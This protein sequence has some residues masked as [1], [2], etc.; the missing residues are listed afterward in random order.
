[1]CIDDNKQ[2][3]D[4]RSLLDGAVERQQRTTMT[5]VRALAPALFSSDTIRRTLGGRSLKEIYQDVLEQDE[6]E[7]LDGANVDMATKFTDLYKKL[8]D[9]ETRI[10]ELRP[11]RT[12]DWGIS[13]PLPV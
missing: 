11:G 7:F 3:M 12:D 8:R 9:I 10:R 1:M 5:A 6:I 13:Q 4:V 2:A